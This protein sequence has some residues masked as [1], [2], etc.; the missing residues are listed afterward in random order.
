MY[1]YMRDTPKHNEPEEPLAGGIHAADIVRVGQT[2]RR[3]PGPNNAFAHKLLNHLEQVGFAG[4]PRF[5][6]TDDQGRDMLTYLDGEVFHGVGDIW[7]ETQ[8]KQIMMLLRAFHAATSGTELA[9]TEE[10]VC[11]NDFASHNVVFRDSVPFAVIDF[12]TAAPGP[13]IRDI[14]YALWCWL[15]LSRSSR[16]IGETADRMRLMCDAYGLVDRS[17]ILEE[18]TKRQVEVQRQHALAGRLERAKAIDNHMAWLGQHK[19]ALQAA[20]N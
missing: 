8:L 12:D 18:I 2:V 4:A 17:M 15:D 3:Y 20:L 16:P 11:H 13:R 5:L 1:I 7:S 6:G 19:A 10:V 14:S 9:G